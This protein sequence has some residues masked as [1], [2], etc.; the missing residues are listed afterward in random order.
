[1]VAD[2]DQ[3]GRLGQ[4]E[5]T[6]LSRRTLLLGGLA[7]IPAV[8]A[9]CRSG[10]EGRGATNTNTTVGPS[11][12]TGPMTTLAPTPACADD[13]DP[14]ASQTEGPFFTPNSPEKTSFL[15]DVD[16]GTP[17]V[18]AG[19]VLTNACQPVARAL[20]DVWHSDDEGRYDNEGYRLR[21]HLFTDSQGRYRLE[22]IVPGLYSGRT[23]HLHV[24]V[25][26]RQ[27][28]AVLTTQLYF[29]GEAANNR[30]GIFRPELLMQVK[31]GAGRKDATFNFVVDA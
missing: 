23:R 26:A 21:G 2:D 6:V 15:A 16:R 9:S 31:E 29:P 25:Q 4:F 20:L 8:V 13:N 7:M 30:D 11:G 18:L 10:D 27:P 3:K 12:A 24:K 1:M 22:T 14:T 19:S 17:M 5:R 28:G